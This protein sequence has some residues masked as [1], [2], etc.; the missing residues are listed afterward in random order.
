MYLWIDDDLCGVVFGTSRES[1]G[2]SGCRKKI[3]KQFLTSGQVDLVREVVTLPLHR[4]RL[5]S[6]G[7]RQRPQRRGALT[8]HPRALHGD[9]RRILS[10]VGRTSGRVD[11]G[12]YLEGST[13]TDH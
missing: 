4:G 1:S 13:E 8:R 9:Q 6:G 11:Q 7:A 12:G 10:D 3:T 5:A 2:Q